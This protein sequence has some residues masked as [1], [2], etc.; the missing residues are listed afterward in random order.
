[1]D[2]R[3][4]RFPLVDSLRG[5]AALMV[6]GL[7]TL[8]IFAGAVRDDAAI[9]PYV[10]RL[11]SGVVVFL[12]ISGFLLYRPYVR[13]HLFGEE[14]PS[15]ASYAWRRFLRIVPAYWVALLIAALA[16]PLQG[17][18]LSLH[19]A[20]TYFGFAQIYQA[21]T[22]GGGI[23]PAWTL[24]LE[25]TF[26]AMLPIWAA[27][28]RRVPARGPREALRVQ[29]IALFVL[30]AASEAY[31]AIVFATGAVGNARISPALVSLPG[32]LDE[33]GL[34]MALAV[35]SVW[36][37]RAEEPRLVR[38]VARRSA[39]CWLL[40]LGAFVLVSRGIG[41]DGS[42]AGD[43]YTAARY[44]ARNGLYGLLALLLLLPAIFGEE[45]R[46]AVR[47]LLGSKVLLWLGLISYGIYLWHWP[48]LLR[49]S[50][51]GLASVS[52]VHPYLLWGA[53][54]GALA[55]AMGALSYYLIERPALSLKSLVGRPPR[56]PGEAVAE[57]APAVPTSG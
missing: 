53:T 4:R 51:W 16:V 8:G 31:K 22:I 18:V 48:V 23:A 41:L 19:G 55:I 3:A 30:V 27:M 24:G 15:T 9:R 35:A 26:Y 47:R 12:L 13:A 56:M 36:F 34:G 10:A 52:G 43:D 7:H 25:L 40:A 5:V 33:F 17:D 14:P 45:R 29:I 32:Y 21:S 2:A 42:A 11:E 38:L 50:D 1:V 39:V 6:L 54:A 44:Y 37:E 46:D 49:L 57:S 20:L 28:L